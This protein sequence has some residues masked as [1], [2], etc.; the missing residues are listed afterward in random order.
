LHAEHEIAANALDAAQADIVA[1]VINE[2]RDIEPDGV[3]PGTARRQFNASHSKRTA[4]LDLVPRVLI[5]WVK[6][7]G[8]VDSTRRLRAYR[9]K[10]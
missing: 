10:A 4:R 8:T 1:G 9:P 3:K 2:I 7:I 6:I 5:F